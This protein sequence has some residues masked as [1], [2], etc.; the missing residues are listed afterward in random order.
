MRS[1]AGQ[2]NFGLV[3]VNDPHRL[4]SV[5]RMRL[6]HEWGL[7][8]HLHH[9]LLLHEEVLLLLRG[10]LS[11]RRKRALLLRHQ[12]GGMLLPARLYM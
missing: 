4:L 7:H 10:Q 6:R 1:A 2:R 3:V 11:A 8:L 5:W 9:G 12:P